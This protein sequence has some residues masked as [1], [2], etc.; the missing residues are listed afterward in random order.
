MGE[1]KLEKK[2]SFAS[3]RFATTE[4]QTSRVCARSNTPSGGFCR[5]STAWPPTLHH[6]TSAPPRRPSPRFFFI[7]IFSADDALSEPSGGL[8]REISTCITSKTLKTLL[9]HWSDWGLLLHQFANLLVGE[10]H[11]HLFEENKLR[12]HS[13]HRCCLDPWFYYKSPSRNPSYLA[14]PMIRAIIYLLQHVYIVLL[15][16]SSFPFRLFPSAKRV[17]WNWYIDSVLGYPALRVTWGAGANPSRLGAKVACTLD[18]SP[19]DRRKPC[20]ETKNY[21]HQ[22]NQP[23]VCVFGL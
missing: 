5:P 10:T 12:D 3:V 15:F 21:H 18:K 23:D 11:T 4:R 2:C 20:G 13:K 6:E 1:L 17:V 16:S 22:A 8:A 14:N 7:I 19:V 9:L